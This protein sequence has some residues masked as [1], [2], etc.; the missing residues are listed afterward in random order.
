M[1]IYVQREDDGKRVLVAIRCDG[2]GAEIRP[3]PE[4]SKSGWEKHGWDHGPGTEKF[5]VDYCPS[6]RGDKQ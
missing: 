3:N 2:C 1:R 4:I 6:C 5:E